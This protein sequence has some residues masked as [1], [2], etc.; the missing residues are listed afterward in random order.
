MAGLSCGITAVKQYLPAVLGTDTVRWHVHSGSRLGAWPHVVGM[1]V[2][3]QLM[4]L[5][6]H[7][8]EWIHGDLVEVSLG[9]RSNA[10]CSPGM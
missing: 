3:P 1:E 8:L 7:Q 4:I 9:R 6:A 2:S 5:S 10:W